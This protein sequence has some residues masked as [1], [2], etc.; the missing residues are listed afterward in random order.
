MRTRGLAS[1][2]VHRH[3]PTEPLAIALERAYGAALYLDRTHAGV[4]DRVAEVVEA[5]TCDEPWTAMRWMILGALVR[6]ACEGLDSGFGTSHTDHALRTLRLQ[7][8]LALRESYAE[9]PIGA[10]DPAS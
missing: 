9:I 8:A 2:A 1:G 4:A 7:L 10:H 3:R 5:A 6:R